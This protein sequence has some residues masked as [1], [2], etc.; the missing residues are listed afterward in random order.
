MRSSDIG[1]QAQNCCWPHAQLRQTPNH[2]PLGSQ[3]YVPCIA[4]QNY[5]I[6]FFQFDFNEI[7]TTASTFIRCIN[8]S[9]L[10]AFL[11]VTTFGPHH[12]WTEWG[13]RR[14]L[15]PIS[16]TRAG[17]SC[18]QDQDKELGERLAT[19]LHCSRVVL[20]AAPPFCGV[21]L[22]KNLK[23][24]LQMPIQVLAHISICSLLCSLSKS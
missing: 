13:P 22:Y 11:S 20:V 18:L 5:L 12:L 16:L 21:Y 19:T 10:A 1:G 7:H 8:A 24:Y 6:L 15:A 3:G 17:K 14:A 4:V 2:F 23:I 9:A